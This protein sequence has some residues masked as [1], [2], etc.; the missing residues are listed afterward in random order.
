MHCMFPHYQR[1]DYKSLY[2]VLQN[3][4]DKSDQVFRVNTSCTAD[5]FITT[6]C[7][8]FCP[9]GVE[10]VNNDYFINKYGQKVQRGTKC[11]DICSDV[12]AWLADNS[13]NTALVDPHHCQDSC[14]VPGYGC[15]A[16][17]DKSYNFT[18][19]IRGEEHCLHPE[20]VCDGHSVCDG[21]E[22]ELLENCAGRFD[23]AATMTCR[24]IMY[25]G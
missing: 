21:G 18:C 19:N 1:C 3:C 10:I 12:S 7:Q 20:L 24:S 16:C 9:E 6:Y 13:A 22:D 15:Q 2:D 25:P 11:D 8:T 4:E 17:T 23:E 14:A 5:T